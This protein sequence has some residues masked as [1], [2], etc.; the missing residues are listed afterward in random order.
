KTDQILHFGKQ[1]DQGGTQGEKNKMSRSLEKDKVL[2]NELINLK[3]A[4]ES[5]TK[6]SM[7][8]EKKHKERKML[9]EHLNAEFSNFLY[10]LDKIKFL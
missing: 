10:T 7:I 9:I 2:N 4:E 5:I 6:E 8:I 3:N 1:E